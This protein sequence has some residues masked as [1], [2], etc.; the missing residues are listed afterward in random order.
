MVVLMV[1]ECC[2]FTLCSVLVACDLSILNE[3][4]FVSGN[5]E[6]TFWDFWKG[7]R[8]QG[9]ITSGMVEKMRVAY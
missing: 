1:V 3:R 6:R 8:M 9:I 5:L 7:C 2:C 4:N